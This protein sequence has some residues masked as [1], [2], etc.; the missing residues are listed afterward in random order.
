VHIVITRFY[1]AAMA[2]MQMSVLTSGALPGKAL[3]VRPKAT[4]AQVR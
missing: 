3:A 4:R 1:S 2:A